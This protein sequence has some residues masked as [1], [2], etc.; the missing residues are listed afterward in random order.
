MALLSSHIHG[1]KFQ[2]VHRASD[3]KS[4]NVSV[5]PPMF[6]GQANPIRRDTVQIEAGASATLRFVADNWGVWFFH[7]TYGFLLSLLP[8]PGI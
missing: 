1:H 4:T 2:I 5:N 7:C 8:L 6:E 3:Y